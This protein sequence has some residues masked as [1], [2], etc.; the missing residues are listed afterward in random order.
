MDS[1]GRHGTP[2][3][4]IDKLAHQWQDIMDG[5]GS[6]EALDALVDPM[7]DELQKQVM[8]RMEQL[9]PLTPEQ[10]HIDPFYQLNYYRTTAA[11]GDDESTWFF[12]SQLSASTC[13]VDGCEV[14][15]DFLAK[16]PLPEHL[17]GLG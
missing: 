15:P 16:Y 3:H 8:D 6:Q 10:R 12:L 5:N 9:W 4:D 13:K 17:Q 1:K 14:C 7:S 2:P 11:P